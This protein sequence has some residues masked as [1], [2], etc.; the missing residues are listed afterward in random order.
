MAHNCFPFT[1]AIIKLHAQ[2]PLESRICL[3][4]I[5]IKNLESLNWVTWGV[6]VPLGQ[7]HSSFVC[8][9]SNLIPKVVWD[10]TPLLS[11]YSTRITSSAWRGI[12]TTTS[13]SC[14]AYSV[15]FT[16]QY[17]DHILCLEGNSHHHQWQLCCLLC[18]FHFTVPGSHPVP[19]GEFPPPPVAA[20][21]LSQMPPP[22]C[23][24]VSLLDHYYTP[25]NEVR[26]GIL[27]SPCPS[28][29]PSVRL[30]VRL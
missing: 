1:S 22:E 25:R 23:F 17:P 6:F 26:G 7:P 9:P 27:E 16:L 24:Q 4:D 30:S 29:R 12:P 10:F 8:K 2:I 28:V 19:G 21:L 15:T 20:L 11:L 18:Y 14:V 5:G 13:C 3:N